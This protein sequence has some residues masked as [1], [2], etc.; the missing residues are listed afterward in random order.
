[1]NGPEPKGAKGP[2]GDDE[3]HHGWIDQNPIRNAIPPEVSASG[4]IKYRTHLAG[5]EGSERSAASIGAIRPI[6]EPIGPIFRDPMGLSTNER[7]DPTVGF[8]P[9]LILEKPFVELPGWMSGKLLTE[10][11]GAWALHIGQLLPAIRNQFPFQL[12]G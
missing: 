3:S 2:A 9:I 5:Q 1:V 10:I 7:S 8:A 6:F 4:G 12:P 11:N